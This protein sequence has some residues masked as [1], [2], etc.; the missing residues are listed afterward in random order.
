MKSVLLFVFTTALSLQVGA[1]DYYEEYNP[2]HQFNWPVSVSPAAK[3]EVASGAF[4]Y[5]E[6]YNANEA[7]NW[8]SNEKSTRLPAQAD[9]PK[10]INYRELEEYNP[11]NEF[12]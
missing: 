12:N 3:L 2:N 10:T 11:H 1:F 4:I 6:E 7:F 9:S 5:P 8:Q